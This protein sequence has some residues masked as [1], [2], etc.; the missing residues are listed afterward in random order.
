VLT[1][2]ENYAAFIVRVGPENGG[3]G[4]PPRYYQ[5]GCVNVSCDVWH[6]TTAGVCIILLAE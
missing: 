6:F 2:L 3:C 4:L 1:V 5:I